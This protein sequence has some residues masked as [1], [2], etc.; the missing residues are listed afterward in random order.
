MPPLAGFAQRLLGGFGGYSRRTRQVLFI[1]RCKAREYG[2]NLLDV[3]HLLMGLIYEDIGELRSADSDAREC[4]RPIIRKSFFSPEMGS[5]LIHK[6]E[7]TLTHSNPLPPSSTI[8]MSKD[9]KQIL[10]FACNL[11]DRLKQKQVQPLHHLVAALTQNSFQA[12]HLLQQA[13]IT[14]EGVIAA[15]KAGE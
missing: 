1:A 15:V 4:L 10:A 5:D 2:S 9:V 6:L 13:G 14:Q 8:P 7:E 11:A 12:S 3:N